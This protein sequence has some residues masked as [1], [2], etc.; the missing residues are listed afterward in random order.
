MSSKS[1][2]AFF[3]R[4]AALWFAVFGLMAGIYLAV[5]PL[6]MFRWREDMMPGGYCPNRGVVSVANFEHFNPDRHYD[7]FIIGSS[8]SMY[9][10]VEHWLRYLPDGARPF[11]FD[12]SA[13]DVRELGQI[14]DYLAS[15]AELKNALIV[16]DWMAFDWQYLDEAPY[17]TPPA[18]ERDWSEK[19]ATHYM[20][21]SN[22]YGRPFMNDWISNIK[23]GSKARGEVKTPRAVKMEYSHDVDNEINEICRTVADSIRQN[24]S[25]SLLRLYPRKAF[26]DVT[27]VYSALTEDHIDR[28]QAE[29][30]MEVGAKLDSLGTDYYFVMVPSNMN[31]IPSP[32]DE[33]IMRRAFGDR[34]VLTHP[35]MTYICRNPY[36]YFAEGY[37]LR[38]RILE[39]VMDFVY[40]NRASQ[41]D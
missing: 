14:I 20:F 10:P 3:A 17:R 19:I 34:Y 7:S 18:V 15:K 23:L 13:L 38:P 11:H 4:A 39:K 1:P 6:G 36:N 32:H 31:K 5:D 12:C 21:F 30:I 25:D 37:H 41:I 26:E 8:L 24:S 28:R 40:T 35:Y 27:Y 29:Y 22:W 2:F 9:Y 33:T 16:W